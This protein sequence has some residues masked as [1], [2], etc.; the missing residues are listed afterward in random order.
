M[1]HHRHAPS[2]TPS[3]LHPPYPVI[4]NQLMSGNG[5]HRNNNSDPMLYHSHGVVSNTND[6]HNRE[7]F[8]PAL[9][10]MQGL[11]N[12]NK[13]KWNKNYEREMMTMKENREV[14]M[15]SERQERFD[16]LITDARRGIRTK[17]RPLNLYFASKNVIVDKKIKKFV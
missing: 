1:N 10:Q 11:R 9:A 14:L 12:N 6:G 13:K 7:N 17:Q 16:G 4:P 3:Q 2:P 5:Y 15:N 8:Q